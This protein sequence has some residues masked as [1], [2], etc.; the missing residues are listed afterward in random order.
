MIYAVNSAVA[1]VYKDITGNDYSNPIVKKDDKNYLNVVDAIQANIAEPAKGDYIIFNYN[2]QT[3]EIKI[4]KNINQVN[5]EHNYIK[6]GVLRAYSLKDKK[7]VLS[8]NG[9][10]VTLNYD[11]SELLYNYIA[12][13]PS[14]VLQDYFGKL[15]NQ[16]VEYVVL[17][18]KLVDINLVASTAAKNIIV[19][20]YAGISSDGTIVVFGYDADTLEYGLYRVASYNNWDAGDFF[21][22]PDS[23]KSINVHQNVLDVKS[24]DSTTNTYY[25]AQNA[26][27]LKA[28][29]IKYVAKNLKSVNGDEKKMSN[30][31]K[32]IIIVTDYATVTDFDASPVIVY[33]GKLES[34]WSL[35]GDQL[36]GTNIYLAKWANINGFKKTKTFEYVIFLGYDGSAAGY[37]EWQKGTTVETDWYLLGATTKYAIGRHVLDLTETDTYLTVNSNLTKGKIYLAKDGIIFGEAKQLTTVEQVVN[38]YAEKINGSKIVTISKA[39]LKKYLE[40]DDS[41]GRKAFSLEVISD[42]DKLIPYYAGKAFDDLISGST[43]KVYFIKDPTKRDLDIKD[44]DVVVLNK[45]NVGDYVKGDYVTAYVDFEEGKTGYVYIFAYDVASELTAHIELDKIHGIDVSAQVIDDEVIVL[46]EATIW[47]YVAAEADEADEGIHWSEEDGEW[48]YDD[49]TVVP[50]EELS[51]TEFDTEVKGADGVYTATATINGEAYVVT[52]TIADGEITATPA[53]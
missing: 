43:P 46:P 50:V 11:Y 20:K 4:V 25:V 28:A 12:S 2:K 27:N 21:F 19:D 13:D 26:Y 49:G 38:Y 35:T 45:D 6:T 47:A 48:Y 9:K 14:F 18:D 15:L 44:P 39:D 51:V 7:V 30:D 8:Y 53:E 36:D 40:T 34:G 31:D 1:D 3:G 10:D 29:D 42:A 24:Y 23:N 5:D 37:D 33:T 22:Y 32:Y 16:Y 41:K 52:I 17:D